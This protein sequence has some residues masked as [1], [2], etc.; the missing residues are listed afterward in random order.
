MIR[1]SYLAKLSKVESEE[2][3]ERGDEETVKMVHDAG[4]EKLDYDTA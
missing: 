4:Q 2:N 3:L 1:S